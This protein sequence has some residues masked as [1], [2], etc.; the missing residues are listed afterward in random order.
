MKKLHSGELF[1]EDTIKNAEYLEL[2]ADIN[3]DVVVIG[4]G[5]SGFG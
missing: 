1:W 3:C 5:I 4:G 2:N